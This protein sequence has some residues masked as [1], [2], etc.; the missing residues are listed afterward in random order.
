[1]N[2][3]I[4]HK[5]LLYVR[6]NKLNRKTFLNKLKDLNYIIRE[7]LWN[8]TDYTFPIITIDPFNKIAFSANTTIMACYCSQGGRDISEEKAVLF[9]QSL[10]ERQTTRKTD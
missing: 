2:I 9:L 6:Y 4:A 1:M 10:I 3:D 5:G 7:H 8:E